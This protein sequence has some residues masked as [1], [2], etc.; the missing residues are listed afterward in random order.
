MGDA[1]PS[2]V[3]AAVVLANGSQLNISAPGWIPGMSDQQMLILLKNQLLN[4]NAGGV[5]VNGRDYVI[6]VGRDLLA[7]AALNNEATWGL[8][9]SGQVTFQ[10]A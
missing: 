8:L 4:P 6:R 1:Q 10:P 5:T 3:G 9:T 7:A 2:N